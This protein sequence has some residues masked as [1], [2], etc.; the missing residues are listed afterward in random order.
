LV[1]K[2]QG[3]NM[4]KAEPKNYNL[5]VEKLTQERDAEGV[6]L[7]DLEQK[8]STAR[9]EMTQA[10]KV[11]DANS[12]DAETTD[13]PAAKKKL[14]DAEELF[15]R[16][17][18]R[19][20]TLEI[21][22]RKSQEKIKHLDDEIPLANARAA[23]RELDDE[24][25]E[26]ITVDALELQQEFEKFVAKK[27]SLQQRM[28]RMT[29]QAMRANITSPHNLLLTRLRI[30]LDDRLRVAEGRDQRYPFQSLSE[31]FRGLRDNPDNWQLPEELKAVNE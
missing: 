9:Q 14:D 2:Q 21:A 7:R 23:K 29:K 27:L 26:A 1:K 24:W 5:E 10:E 3:E 18:Q 11:V 8:A 25:E 20:K 13:D 17:T 31:V 30:F 4:K 28:N 6:K 12:Y 15:M 22:I 16:A 19:L